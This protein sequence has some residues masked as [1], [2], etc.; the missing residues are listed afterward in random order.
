[1]SRPVIKEVEERG[2]E[3]RLGLH[4]HITGLGL[5]EKLKAIHVADGLVGQEEAREAAGIMVELVKRG[6]RPG[7]GLLLVGPPGTGKTAIA[8][9]MARELGRDVPFVSISGSEIYGSTLK[10]TELL[11]QAIRRAVGLR[12]YEEKE[13]YEG[14]VVNIEI[15][16]A[17]H[18][19]NPY[20]QV[21]LG[22]FLTLRTK[23]EE[24]SLEVG[25][26]VAN[27]LLRLNV[28]PGDVIEIEAETGHVKKLGRSKQVESKWKG[29]YRIGK[30]VEVPSGPVKKVKKTTHTVTLHDVDMANIR[31]GRIMLFREEEITSEI[32]AKVDE[33]VDEAVK[34]KKAELVPG[35]LFIDEA[36]MLDIEAFSFLNRA[37]EQEYAPLV[38]LA[39]NRAVTKIRGTDFKSPHGIPIDMLDRLLIA[40]TK[41]PPPEDVRKILEIKA[42]ADGIELSPE[43]LD[44]LTDIGVKRTLRY[45]AQLLQP[46]K[47]VAEIS[48]SNVVRPEHVERVMR[49]YLDFRD[50]ISYLNEE[51]K[52]DPLLSEFLQ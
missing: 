18:P 22:A 16:K 15:E 8:V 44:M 12:L 9:G 27:Q 28:R 7:H 35:V 26:R 32:R 1:M 24:K 11:T 50:S 19:Y 2:P 43:T 42:L 30:I 47:V 31:A 39:T 13:V 46:A 41:I 45:A 33:Q 51:L 38:V 21:A 52:K 25:E 10:K 29:E 5:D 48:G 3:R 23:Q 36:H 40:K 4:G 17:S 34:S 14:E 37:L 6:K 49:V 20:V